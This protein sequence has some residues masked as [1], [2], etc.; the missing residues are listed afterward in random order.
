MSR[1]L[2]FVCTIA[3]TGLWGTYPSVGFGEEPRVFPIIIG[4]TRNEPKKA[5]KIG[6]GVQASGEDLGRA[7]S[8]AF[9]GT[10]ITWIGFDQSSKH[11][12][13][14]PQTSLTVQTINQ[15]VRT[16]LKGNALRPK[17]GPNDTIF[18]YILAHG[19]HD[20]AVAKGA[21]VQAEYGHWFNVENEDFYAR[22]DLFELLLDQR[23]PIG[24]EHRRSGL[25][26]LISDTCN[27]AVRTG[28][29]FKFAAGRPFGTL[30]R[31]LTEY[32]GQVSISATDLGQFANYYDD[33]S[34][35]VFTK[36]FL[37]A[38]Q[39]DEE[40]HWSG[41]TGLMMRLQVASRDFVIANPR[42]ETFTPK[43]MRPEARVTK[44]PVVQPVPAPM[45]AP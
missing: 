23:A 16:A 40:M 22:S 26:V 24:D 36:L 21:G 4:L 20:P 45:P 30:K 1:V 6:K 38:V 43:W 18:C 8:I 9:P 15:E 37:K 19:A 44:R 33:D 10:P 14:I 13:S 2:F 41:P 34:G 3:G 5:D 35:G 32:Q 27:T 7:L 11:G 31:L 29:P 17:V 42:A 39:N 25:T 28:I 12:L